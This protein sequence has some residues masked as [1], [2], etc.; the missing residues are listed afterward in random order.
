MASA[1]IYSSTT[2]PLTTT[3]EPKSLVVDIVDFGTLSTE[4]PVVGKSDEGSC[5]VKSWGKNHQLEERPF[6]PQITMFDDLENSGDDAISGSL[7]ESV[8]TSETGNACKICK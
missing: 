8:S 7:E 2:V 4:P 6:V 1:D 5:G 3:S